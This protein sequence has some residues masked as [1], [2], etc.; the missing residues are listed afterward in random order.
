[1]SCHRYAIKHHGFRSRRRY[2][3]PAAGVDRRREP[4]PQIR[5]LGLEQIDEQLGAVEG[6]PTI[7]AM[8]AT[9]I[10]AGLRREARHY[11]EASRDRE[12]TPAALP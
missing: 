3:N 4:A 11:P 8:V 10:Y 1:M 6:H 12:P 7:H 5:F 9:Y 2:P